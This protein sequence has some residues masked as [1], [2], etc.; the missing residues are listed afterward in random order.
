LKFAPPARFCC[1][2][3]SRWQAFGVIIAGSDPNSQT[4]RNRWTVIRLARDKS[5]HFKC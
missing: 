2:A 5:F 4:R 1:R 3:H